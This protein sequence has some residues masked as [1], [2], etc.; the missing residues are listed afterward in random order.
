MGA[1]ESSSVLGEHEDLLRQLVSSKPIPA[2]AIFWEDLLEFS[3]PLPKLKPADLDTATR[4]AC[5]SLCEWPSPD[6]KKAD[7]SIPHV[8][9]EHVFPDLFLHAPFG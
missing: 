2:N 5:V 1:A 6:E 7:I 3:H 8:E 9:Y 4:E